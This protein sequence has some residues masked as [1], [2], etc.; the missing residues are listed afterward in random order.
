MMLDVLQPG[1][2]AGSIRRAA[3]SRAHCEELTVCSEIRVNSFQ[4]RRGAGTTKWLQVRFKGG[5]KGR[6]F[7][8]HSVH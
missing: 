2:G 3:A 1:N 7:Y 8:L 4:S 5:S 6:I